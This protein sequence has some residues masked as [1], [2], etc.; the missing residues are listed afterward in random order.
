MSRSQVSQAAELQADCL[1]AAALNGAVRDGTPRTQPADGEQISRTS[2]AAADRYPWTSSRD[3]GN[4]QQR[5]AAFDRGVR[6]GV[7]ACTSQEGPE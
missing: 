4:A 3:H 1:G 7:P 6:G 2:G 5:R